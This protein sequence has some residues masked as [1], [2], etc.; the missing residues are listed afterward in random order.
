MLTACYLLNRVPNKRNKINPYELWTKRKPNLNYLRV[1]GCKALVRVPDPNLKTL[2]ERGIECIFVGYA[3]HSKIFRF[4]VIEPNDSVLINSIIES[5]PRPSIRILNGTK[6]IGGSMVPEKATE[7]KEAINDEIDSTMGNNTWVLVDL[8]PGCKPLGCKWIFKRKLKMDVKTTFSNGDL[9]EEQVPKQWHQKFDEVVLSNGYLLNQADKCV[10]SNFDE[11]GKGVIICLYVDNMLIFGTDQGTD[12]TR[13]LRLNMLTGTSRI[14]MNGLGKLKKLR[15][16]EV[17]FANFDS[18]TD[19]ESDGECLGSDSKFDDTSQLDEFNNSDL[20]EKLQEDL[21]K[22]ECLEKLN[23]S[24]KKIEYLPDS[25]CR[26][27][28]LKELYVTECYRL[29]KLPEDIV[30]LECLER[31]YLSSTMI[32]HLPGGICML[33]HQKYLNRFDCALLEKLPEDLG[34]L[35]CLEQLDITYTGISLLPQSIFGLKALYIAAP[36]ELLQL[37][38]FPKP[39]PLALDARFHFEIKS[40]E[41]LID[42]LY[43]TGQTI[44]SLMQLDLRTGVNVEIKR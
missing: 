6:D 12:A 18:E 30:Q 34:R 44:D 15:Y 36:P 43:P 29:G 21:G 25:I 11:T 40:H 22:L 33:K 16:L 28:R 9:D 17:Y 8:P 13:C 32:K 3:E 19:Y 38:D 10:Y 5:V 7:E 14:L 37:Y 1:W 35:E 24:S 2:G 27:K 41:R 20:L 39:Q 4:Y 42:T 31:L 26:L 23:V